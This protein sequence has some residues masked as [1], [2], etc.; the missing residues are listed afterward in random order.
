MGYVVYLL[1]C[2]DGSLYTGITTDPARRFSEHA[3][4]RGRGAKYT[5]A[6][7]PVRMEAAFC[8]P[9]R[10]AASRIE[11]RIKRLSHAQ[12]EQLLGDAPMLDGQRLIRAATDAEG[13]EI[14]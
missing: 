14:P 9:D 4:Q 2:A 7:R 11:R 8:A 12:K 3:G 6:H 13:R 1:R 5:A 10:A